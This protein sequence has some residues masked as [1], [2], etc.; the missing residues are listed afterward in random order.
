[1]AK[2]W[3]VPSV[4]DPTPQNTNHN[5]G[6][7]YGSVW[8]ESTSVG[9]TLGRRNG[10]H[11]PLCPTIQTSQT[12]CRLYSA[13]SIKASIRSLKVEFKGRFGRKSWAGKWIESI[14]ESCILDIASISFAFNVWLLLSLKGVEFQA[15][16][17]SIRF[18]SSNRP[19]PFR[20]NSRTT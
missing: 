10:A 17:F 14:P 2:A 20:R 18:D 19:N 15:I 6:F 3:T 13:Y 1:M 5:G 8:D 7:R 4:D 11:S 9:W 12:P 16:C